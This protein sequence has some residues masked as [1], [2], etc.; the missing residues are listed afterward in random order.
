MDPS[1][2]LLVGQQVVQVCLFIVAA[3]AIVGG[4]LQMVLGQPDTLSRLD[5]L[6]RFIAG[7]YFSTGVISFW[8]AY[9]IRQQ[10]TLVY[11]LALGVFLAGVGRLV[12]IRR[13]G[14]PKPA[15][16]WLGYLIPELLL[17]V[18]IVVAWRLSTG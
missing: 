12:S 2:P 13:V 17:P 7:V 10:G 11:L 6:H 14:L 5:N 16:V 1:A 18:V 4:A 15:A 9:T 3:I 8:A